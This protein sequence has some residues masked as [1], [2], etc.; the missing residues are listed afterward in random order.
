MNIIL[1]RAVIATAAVS[2]AFTMAACG[3][4]GDSKSTTASAS[5]GFKIGLALPENQTTRYEAVDRPKIEAKIK[6]LCPSCTMDYEN[7]A[8]NANTQQ[9]QIQTL[10]NDGDK[11]IIVDAVD[12]KA[13]QPSIEAAHKKGI[14]I[15]AYDRLAQGPVDAYVS[16]DNEKVGEQQG[17]ALLAAM[18][19]KATPSSKIIMVN[20]DPGDPNAAQFKAGALKVLQGK[21]DIAAKFD[22]TGWL[23]N[24]AN[25]EVA[26]SISRIGAKNIA[27]V[28]SA[29]DGMAAGVV[30]ALQ[31]AHI[32]PIPPVSGQDSQ[33]DGVQR[34][35]AGTQ[36]FTIYKP[37][38]TEADDA[39]TMAIDLVTGKSLSAVAD[40]TQSSATNKNIPSK[41][42]P[43]VVLTNKNVQQTVVAS[44]LYTVQAICTPQYKAACDKAGLK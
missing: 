1:R 6:Q 31:A 41:L 4:A 26:G 39:A 27:A 44:G 23:A 37:Y 3:K 33:I 11:A 35:L 14:K 20:G 19:S 38:T 43:T 34:V 29:N 42:I 2:M 5:K 13:I 36:A 21:V 32:K 10:I 9:Q 40:T 30:S 7:A 16:F 28:Y 17:T 8:Q 18:G 12:F 22:T 15:V 25:Q 24:N